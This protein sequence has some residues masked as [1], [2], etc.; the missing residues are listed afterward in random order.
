MA[1]KTPEHGKI[2]RFLEIAGCGVAL[3]ASSLVV[4]NAVSVMTSEQ[5][6]DRT[7]VEECI[8]AYRQGYK[9]SLPSCDVA[10]A[11]SYPRVGEAVAND[12]LYAQQLADTLREQAPDSEF[13][14]TSGLLDSEQML[15]L[16]V[17]GLLIG[18]IA[19]VIRDGNL[20]HT[21]SAA[22][23]AKTT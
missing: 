18:G 9:D 4:A 22:A 14:T 7:V 11:G 13:I 17:A 8:T 12:Q 23:S 10:L 1:N 2:R 3:S 21:G 15:M 5:P 6:T 20:Y 16:G 19:G